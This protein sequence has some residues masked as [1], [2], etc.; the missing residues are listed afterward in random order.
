LILNRVRTYEQ[1]AALADKMRRISRQFLGREINFLGSICRDL[2][3][4]DFICSHQIIMQVAPGSP[5]AKSIRA[6][7]R[8][9]YGADGSGEAAGETGGIKGYFKK[10][11]GFKALLRM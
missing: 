10:L 3:V 1:G 11:L 6:I 8:R 2:R 7:A 9:F 5:T 4:E